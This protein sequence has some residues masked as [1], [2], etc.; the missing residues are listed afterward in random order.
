MPFSLTFN[1]PSV[2]AVKTHAIK[3]P[4]QYDTEINVARG[5]KPPSASKPTSKSK[6]R[7]EKG[8]TYDPD[9]YDPDENLERHYKGKTD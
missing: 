1:I 7:V 5:F 2:R 3:D 6:V 8:I 9:Q 4:A